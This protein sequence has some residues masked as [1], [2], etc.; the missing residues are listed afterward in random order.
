MIYLYMIEYNIFMQQIYAAVL[1]MSAEYICGILLYISA[2][3]MY[4]VLLHISAAYI[5]G[6]LL[7]PA[8]VSPISSI[9]A[10]DTFVY[11]T[12]MFVYDICM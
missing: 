4:G 8:A 9:I 1:H 11:N 10:C 7:P 6:V 5:Y 12:N 2:A 3:Y